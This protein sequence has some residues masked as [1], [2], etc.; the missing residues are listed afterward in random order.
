[1]VQIPTEI[2]IN[3]PNSMTTKQ[4]KQGYHIWSILTPLIIPLQLTKQKPL[5]KLTS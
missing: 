4:K 5:I 3:G 2:L 1:M